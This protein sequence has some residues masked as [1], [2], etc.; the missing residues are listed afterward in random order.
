MK[1]FS[2][3]KGFHKLAKDMRE[4]EALS[5]KEL[6]RLRAITV[7]GRTKDIRLVCDTFGIS[8]ATLYRWVKGYRPK[9]L[10]SLKEHSRRPRHVRKPE[11]SRDL[12]QAVKD[13]REQYPRWGKDKLVV[14]LRRDGW[15][16][17]VSTVGRI[18]TDLKQRGRL[19][20]PPRKAIS[21]KRRRTRPYAERKPKG[22]Q[23]LAPGDLVQID[24]LDIRPLPGVILKQFTARDMI[25]RWDVLEV[26]RRATAR[27]AEAFL[28]TLTTRMP[29][30][31]KAIQV[32]DRGR[33]LCGV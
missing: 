31:V 15:H 32:D 4:G 14:L 10:S 1:V 13:L 22:Y 6:N 2:I 23:V 27:M 25:S 28:H 3:A 20:E 29:F 33:V 11:W 16:T 17:S 8:R 5:E 30:A 26:H 12:A 18:L 24:T 21:A 7:V 9:D 19:V